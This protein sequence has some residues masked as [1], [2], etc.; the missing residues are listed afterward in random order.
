MEHR[1]LR[2]EDD[3]PR[4][5][6]Q[7]RVQLRRVEEPRRAIVHGRQFV[8]V[9]ESD[10]RSIR[11]TRRWP[12]RS[13]SPGKRVFLQA[14]YTHQYFSFGS[15]TVSAFYDAHPN[16]SIPG[17]RAG[18]RA[19][20][21]YVFSGDANGD[22]VSGNDLIYIPRSTSEM[23]FKPLHGRAAKTFTA[24]DQAAA[25]EQYIQND[26]YLS[27]HR[28][29]YAERGAVFYPMVNRIDLSIIQDVFHS[30]GGAKHTGQIRLDITNFGNL[31]NHNWGVGQ[32]I[33]N[34][35]ILTSPSVDAQRR[36]HVQPSD[37]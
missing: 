6:V 5:R 10:R 30:L 9:G 14:S 22:T 31:L 16:S 7:G 26:S 24:A 27:S 4:L 1:R 2:L 20:T 13:N 11:T 28:G 15:T 25:F 34:P 32:R 19:N 35:Q 12:T 23:N 18:R 8:G 36:A 37:A 33:I 21:S 3:D 17:L 29:Q